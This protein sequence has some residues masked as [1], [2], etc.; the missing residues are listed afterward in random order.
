MKMSGD[1]VFI[2]VPLRS[3]HGL[4]IGMV[5]FG[6]KDNDDMPISHSTIRNEILNVCSLAK[7]L[8]IV[9]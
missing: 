6:W 3:A 9:K 2:A 1:N 8:L 5:T 4:Q 7:S